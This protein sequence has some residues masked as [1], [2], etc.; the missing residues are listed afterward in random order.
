MT[1]SSSASASGARNSAV[2]AGIVG[3]LVVLV[4][5]FVVLMR[6]LGPQAGSNRRLRLG[7]ALAS[8]LRNKVRH[9]SNQYVHAGKSPQYAD[10][11]SKCGS[12]GW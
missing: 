10:N 9:I 6:N 12:E 8:R 2:G 11:A 1:D 3:V 7:E 4:N 5:F